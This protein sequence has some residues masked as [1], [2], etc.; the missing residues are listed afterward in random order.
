[1]AAGIAPFLCSGSASADATYEAAADATGA[2]L[3]F[4]NQSIPL[5]VSPQAQGPTAMAK[6]TSLHQ[7]DGYAAF[8]DPGQDVVGLPGVAGG[9]AHVP[10]PGY[11]F[12]IATSYGDDI[13]RLSYPGIELSSESGESV[14]QASATGG[15]KGAG[16]TSIARV[17]RDGDAVAATATSDADVLRLGDALVLTGLHASAGALRDATGKLIRTSSLSFTSL[18]VPG[19]AM[20]VPP[21][22][23]SSSPPQK[24]T[25][26]QIGFVDGTFTVT[27][28]GAPANSTPVPAKDVFSAFASAGYRISYQAPQQTT[29][30]IVGAGLQIAT[31]LPAPP[32]GSPGGLSGQTPVTLSMGLSRAEISYRGSQDTPS[33]IASTA[34][35]LTPPPAGG[36][37]LSGGAAP[38]PAAALPPA[39]GSAVVDVP[40]PTAPAAM[41]GGSVDSTAPRSVDFAALTA[42]RK[43]LRTD[44]GWIYLM[45]GAVGVAGA[46]ALLA[47]RWA[48]GAR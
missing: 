45:I 46:L 24:L 34:G 20:S 29:D 30:G 7:S 40:V 18:S 11:P 14:T 5:G 44:V 3:I 39:A 31:T 33:T 15:S 23:G 48:G 47:M 36:V 27:L 35:A 17:T 4:S 38:E 42:N 6:Q 12:A 13:R 28:P 41:G 9:A 25:A 22:P 21:P 37:V 2:K 16:A 1:L 10:L 8:P 43:P 32:P 26:P 19:L